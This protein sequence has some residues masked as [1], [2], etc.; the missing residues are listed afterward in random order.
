MRGGRL[1]LIETGWKTKEWRTE[2]NGVGRMAPYKEKHL[3]KP[4][5][6]LR[7][8]KIE[9]ALIPATYVIPP[10]KDRT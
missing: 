7:K 3:S 9:A 6:F 1:E 10:K 2:G 8:T 4:K 5:P